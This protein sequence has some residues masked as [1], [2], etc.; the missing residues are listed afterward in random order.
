MVVEITLI[1]LNVWVWA[2]W[3]YLRMP[4]RGPHR[5]DQAIFQLGRFQTILLAAVTACYGQRTSVDLAAYR[6]RWP[7]PNGDLLAIEQLF[8]TMFRGAVRLSPNAGK[9]HYGTEA[10]QELWSECS[11]LLANAILFYNMLLIADAIAVREARGDAVGAARLLT[12]SP[13][14]WVH[15]NL[16]GRYLFDNEPAT[17]PL[18]ALVEALAQYSFRAHPEEP[19]EQSP[20]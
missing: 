11:R 19:D 5:V 18:A 7:M 12:V 20:P 15:V 8:A 3:H 16:Y 4:G 2:K 6:P 14:A 9:L 1:L 10:D 17:I 13:I